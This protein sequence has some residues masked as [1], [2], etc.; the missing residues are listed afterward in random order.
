MRAP[1]FLVVLTGCLA[2]LA[3]PEVPRDDLLCGDPAAWDDAREA[4][5]KS[6][7][8]G[9][10]S[11]AGWLDEHDVVVATEV[12]SAIASDVEIA[13]GD[14]VLNS[15]YLVGHTPFFGFQLKL[16][17]VG[18]GDPRELELA[19][20]GYTSPATLRSLEDG[21]AG[22]DLRLE[23]VGENVSL[24]VQEGGTLEILEQTASTLT[25][26]FDGAFGPEGA[27][28]TGC[29]ETAYTDQLVVALP[30]D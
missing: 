10:V 26:H 28:V 20:W 4:C 13:P 27:P 1:A 24:V 6:G 7:C 12:T 11:F 17:T 9:I 25:A 5:E 3:E 16:Y 30:E 2:P 15:L 29:F 21:V 19:P 18:D 14:R 23:S 8:P 22:A